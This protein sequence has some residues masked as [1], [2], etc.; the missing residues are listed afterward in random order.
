[1]NPSPDA[2]DLAS[3]I[4]LCCNQLDYTR[5]CLESVLR[6]TH[7]PYEL[8]LVD[9]GSTDGTPTF[10]ENLRSCPGPARVEVIRNATNRGFPAGCN[11]ALAQARGRYLVFLNNDTVVTE[12]WLEGLLAWLPRD[13]PEVGLVG[14]TTNLSGNE[15]EIP[16]AY[17]DLTGLMGFAQRRRQEFAGRGSEVSKLSGFCLVARREVLERIGGLDERFGLGFCDD[18]DWCRRARG[19]GFQLILA[20][21]V[22][23]HHFGGRT[24]I[25]LQV[26]RLQQLNHNRELFQE[27]WAVERGAAAAAMPQSVGTPPA[28]SLA[29][30]G[31]ISNPSAGQH[32]EQDGLE[33]RPTKTSSPSQDVFGIV[34]EGALSALH[35]MSLVNRAFCR[36]LVERG[37]DVAIL[38]WTSQDIGAPS[39]PPI[40]TDRFNRSLTR[41]VDVHIR[42]QWPPNFTPPSAGHWVIM[43]PWEF[44]SMPR[45][46]IGPMSQQVD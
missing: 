35:S 2:A 44:G 40:L 15:Q 13:R 9:N 26:D 30:V 18:V 43:Q 25:D 27:K 8:V 24:F 19:A 20:Q 6:H 45:A 21:D 14:P 5:L 36:R 42:H 38:P 16:V 10:L 17:N 22:F 33:I 29:L 32:C 23:V 37:H 39:L 34:W 4:I 7:V 3:L 41:P 12:G 31:R 11:Q 1:M 28:S 46:W